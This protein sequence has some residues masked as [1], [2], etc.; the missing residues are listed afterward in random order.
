M[1]VGEAR[2][3]AALLVL[4]RGVAELAAG[5]GLD[6]NRPLAHTARRKGARE[7]RSALRSFPGHAQVAP[8]GSH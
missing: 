6:R 2:Y 4:E 3:I 5:I 7:A 8:S 1:I